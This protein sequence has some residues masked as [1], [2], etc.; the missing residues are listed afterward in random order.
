MERKT[1]FLL[2]CI[3]GAAVGAAIGY[4]LASG[5]GEEMIADIKKAADKLKEEFDGQLEKGQEVLNELK[6]FSS[7]AS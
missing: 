7:T 3:A 5:K 4:F 1:A 2:S 6:D